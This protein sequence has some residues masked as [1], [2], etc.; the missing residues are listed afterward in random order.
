MREENKTAIPVAYG[1]V[2]IVVSVFLSN[3]LNQELLARQ[4][5]WIRFTATAVLAVVLAAVFVLLLG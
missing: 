3:I 5:S 1:A 4:P 2:F